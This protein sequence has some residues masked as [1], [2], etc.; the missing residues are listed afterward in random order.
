[1]ARDSLYKLI[2]LFFCILPSP[3]LSEEVDINSSS[4]Q[5]LIDG[6]WYEVEVIVFK[7]LNIQATSEQL[8]VQDPTIWPPNIQSLTSQENDSIVF[9]ERERKAEGDPFCVSDEKSDFPDGLGII[10]NQGYEPELL[11][12]FD[13]TSSQV[14]NFETLS[15]DN[16]E[17]EDSDLTADIIQSNTISEQEDKEPIQN[18]NTSALLDLVTQEITN[19]ED[20][21]RRASFL[22]LADNE[23]DLLVERRLL[24]EE[25]DLVVTHHLS[26]LQN[27]PERGKPLSIMIPRTDAKLAGY[28]RV[29]IGRY[30]HFEAD[31]WMPVEKK[32]D[33]ATPQNNHFAALRESRRM[34]SNELH[35]LDHPAFGII[36][37]ISPYSIESD[38]AQRWLGA[39]NPEVSIN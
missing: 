8:V 2:V 11:N 29:T 27:V 16:T 14:F 5:E 39:Q 13:A 32:D 9:V 36:T 38:V 18:L 22:E 15:L 4:L 21:L 7:R 17:E 20:H 19:F 12:D 3:A 37:K 1:M 31:L 10:L 34:R 25:P 26:W 33:E 30:L 28:V 23:K 24:D 6:K 35:Y